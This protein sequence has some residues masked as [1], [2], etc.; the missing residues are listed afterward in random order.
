MALNTEVWPKSS[1]PLRAKQFELMV[2]HIKSSMQSYLLEIDAD[3]STG[4]L[5][6]QALYQHQYGLTRAKNFLTSVN[7]VGHGRLLDADT[8]AYLVAYSVRADGTPAYPSL[9]SLNADISAANTAFASVTAETNDL[10]VITKSRGQAYDIDANH[11][12]TF[13]TYFVADM[14]AL[15]IAV[16]AL[17]A[18]LG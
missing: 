7:G 18:L 13:Q 1:I 3:P 4:P 10:I 14:A 8:K 9:A 2:A 17:I 15:R 12:I 6:S 11:I 5:T 16:A